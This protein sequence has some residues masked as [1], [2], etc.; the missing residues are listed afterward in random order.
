VVVGAHIDTSARPTYSAVSGTHPTVTNQ[1]DG[2]A[3][4][5]SGAE[6]LDGAPVQSDTS[7]PSINNAAIGG[8]P[9]GSPRR[10]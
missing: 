8:K 2:S 1:V 7:G 6:P 3:P 10:R 4:P 5:R 9:T